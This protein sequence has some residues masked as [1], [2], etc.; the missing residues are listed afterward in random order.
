M[1]AKGG[2]KMGNTAH[3]WAGGELLDGFHGGVWFVF[4][5]HGSKTDLV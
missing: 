2:Y 5:R 1:G 4:V 3:D